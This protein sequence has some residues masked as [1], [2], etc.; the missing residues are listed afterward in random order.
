MNKTKILVTFIFLMMFLCI[1]FVPLNVNAGE[2][3]C[4]LQASVDVIVQVWDAD[5][6]GNKGNTIWKGLIK[7]GEQKP[8]KSRH[9]QIRY[10]STTVID[11]NEPLSG[12]FDRPCYNRGIVGVP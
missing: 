7:Q 9:G 6:E 5:D 10:S 11:E 3:D 1:S 8:I 2:N 4:I 12:D